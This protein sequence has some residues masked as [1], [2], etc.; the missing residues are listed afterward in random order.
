MCM[1]PT[2]HALL[3]PLTSLHKLCRLLPVPVS[4]PAESCPYYF[5]LGLDPCPRTILSRGGNCFL[6]LQEQ[7]GVKF[8][9][10]PNQGRQ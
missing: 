9:E 4:F 2:A 3:C 10:S 7:E 5:Q 6:H 8:S 1:A